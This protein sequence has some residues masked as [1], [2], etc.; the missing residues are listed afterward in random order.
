MAVPDNITLYEPN[1]VVQLNRATTITSGNTANMNVGTI[2]MIPSASLSFS[3]DDIVGFNPSK[4]AEIKQD[5][6]TFYIVDINNIYFKY[7]PPS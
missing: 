2:V 7:S 3:V 4:S 6:N 5:S 1:V